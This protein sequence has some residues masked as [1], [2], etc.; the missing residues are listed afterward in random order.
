MGKY[1]K[2]FT[3][4]ELLVVIA[5]IG[6]IAAI[7]F[8][9]TK[10]ARDKGVDARRKQ[11]L[12]ALSAALV[13]YYT[14]H[15]SY[16][17]ACSP[18]S[19]SFEIPSDSANPWIPEI[20]PI[21]IQKLP[22]DPKQASIFPNLANLFP[23][24]PPSGPPP[25]VAA[26]Q[27][28][29]IPADFD[30]YV[31]QA[32][33]TSFSSSTLSTSNRVG[34]ET[35][36]RYNFRSVIRFPLTSIPAGAT[37]ESVNFIFNVKSGG[38]G[39]SSV[40]ADIQAYN[41]D[42]QA[43]PQADSTASVRHTRAGN[44]T[45]PYIDNSNQMQTLGIKTIPLPAS[46]RTDLASANATVDRFSLAMNENSTAQTDGFNSNVEA[47]E[48]TTGTNKPKLEVTYIPPG[49]TADIYANGSG[50]SISVAYNQSVTIN[51]TSNGT[52]CTITP[53]LPSPPNPLS[54]NGTA[55]AFNATTTTTY[56]LNCNGSGGPATDTVTVNVAAP[57]P[58]TADIFANSTGGS[59]SVAYNASVTISW[60]SNGT[61]CTVSPIGGSGTSGSQT[62]NAITT[63]TYTLNCNGSGG[64]ATD[65]V[66]V[67]VPAPPGCAGKRN[68][69]CY[70][71]STDRL[72]FVLW[73]QLENPNDQ[74][75]YGGPQ[76]VCVLEGT[77]VNPDPTLYNFCIKSP[78]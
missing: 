32:S 54:A 68:V 6:T 22:K 60:S 73:T 19:A 10:N 1:I 45:S 55:P 7:G 47:I 56:T 40:F 61:T 78:K 65:T 75:V 72:S 35:A 16:P 27:T 21:Y 53:A 15:E 2:G 42:G 39:R 12:K 30:A 76:S 31:F 13:S 58:T 41:Q 17:P 52:D 20:S 62:F 69:Y 44:D 11:D 36:I 9:S 51:W 63:T 49:T 57:P 33:A 4:V 28:V 70:I 37:I 43:D 71:A 26:T 77:E 50:G 38:T 14:D 8:I 24:N 48:D 34:R 67:N 3:I 25:R 46:A 66:T 5:V 59:I 74:E 23:R 64:P 29:T 18:C